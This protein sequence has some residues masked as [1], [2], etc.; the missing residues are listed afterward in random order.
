MKYC[1]KCQ[2]TYEDETYEFCLEDGAVLVEYSEAQSSPTVSLDE[3]QTQIKIKPTEQ[4]QFF[5]PTQAQDWQSS[6]VTQISPPTNSAAAG[7]IEHGKSGFADGVCDA[8]AVWRRFWRVV[9]S[10]RQTDGSSSK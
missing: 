10:R 1:P 7:K 2:T 4:V 5:P 6:Q 8:W 3:Q 9:F